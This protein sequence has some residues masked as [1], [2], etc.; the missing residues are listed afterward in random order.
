MSLA[1]ETLLEL[2]QD[3][4]ARR[5][6]RE[7]AEAMKLYRHELAVTDAKAE[8][9]GRRKGRREGRQEGRNEG[10]VE[11]R[12]EIL[13]KQLGLRF[14]R[15]SAA[16]QARVQAASAEELDVWAERILRARSLG[17]VFAR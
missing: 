3:P 15:L 6:A 1:K 4:V 11:G 5:L 2:S 16:N 14:G 8:A 9:R 17:E 12:A 13:L 10:R 7:R